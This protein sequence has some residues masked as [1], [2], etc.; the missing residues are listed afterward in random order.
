MF[1]VLFLVFVIGNAGS[2]I[3]GGPSEGRD[4]RGRAVV[5]VS[6]IVVYGCPFCRRLSARF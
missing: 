1:P 2:A 4:G 3:F 5:A 6:A